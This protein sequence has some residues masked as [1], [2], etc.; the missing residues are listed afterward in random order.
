V[1]DVVAARRALRPGS[2]PAAPAHGDF[3]EGNVLVDAD[4]PWVVDWE[5]SGPR[6]LGYDAM[7]L[8]ATLED[9][10]LRAAFLEAVLAGADAPRRALLLRVRHAVLVQTILR[11]LLPDRSLNRDPAGADRLLRLLAGAR[12]D[13]AG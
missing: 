11:K 7:Q 4:G 12:R 8:W 6:P 9:D 5:L 3:H 2:L 1:A 13:A 10:E